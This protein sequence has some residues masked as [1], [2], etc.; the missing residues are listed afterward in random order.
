MSTPITIVIPLHEIFILFINMENIDSFIGVTA[1]LSQRASYY[2]RQ[3]LLEWTD[4][5]RWD[6]M[7]TVASSHKRTCIRQV[8][9]ALVGFILLVI[10][11]RKVVTA[12]YHLAGFDGPWWAAY[13][14]IWICNTLASGDSAHIFV[15]VNKKY[16]DFARIG[17]N[18]LVTSDPEVTRQILA[19]NSK[20]SRGPWFD[21]LRID[22]RM[23][24]IGKC[25]SG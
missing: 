2:G 22:P 5:G 20:W 13:T 12:R 8:L 11:T 6:D 19:V 24:N 4:H 21:S 7:A 18:H 3:I 15:E 17:P 10:L 25:C 16:G 9:P 1:N 14:R 23:T